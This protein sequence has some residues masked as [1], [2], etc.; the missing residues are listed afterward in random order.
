MELHSKELFENYPRSPKVLILNLEPITVF[1][2]SELNYIALTVPHLIFYHPFSTATA[3]L[4][5]CIS[6]K[7]H[8]LTI[9]SPFDTISKHTEN[10]PCHLFPARLL[11]R[12]SQFLPR[13]PELARALQMC[14][15]SSEMNG[16]VTSLSLPARLSLTQPRRLLAAFAAQACLLPHIQFVQYDPQVF[17]CK[18]AF[19]EVSSQAVSV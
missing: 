12:T 13:S 10:R 7:F 16:I 17:S 1:P 11:A 18:A 9:H 3:S 2:L 19:Q 4:Q 14:L 6:Y 8:H 15:T 5:T